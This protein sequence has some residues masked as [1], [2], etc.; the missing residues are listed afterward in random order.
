M[1]PAHQINTQLSLDHQISGM[2][3]K[4]FSEIKVTFW[5]KVWCK[6]NDSK[7]KICFLKNPQFVK[8]VEISYLIFTEFP[9]DWLKIEDFLKKA[10]FWFT[11]IFFAT[12]LMSPLDDPYKM[13]LLI[14]WQKQG[15]I[16]RFHGIIWIYLAAFQTGKTEEVDLLWEIP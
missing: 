10:Y 8:S 5:P 13:Y 7:S 1:P 15:R 4:Y 16:T 9:N 6:K 14:K 2:I 11:V 12:H 3:S